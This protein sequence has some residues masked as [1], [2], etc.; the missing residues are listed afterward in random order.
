MPITCTAT[1][2][3]AIR[4]TSFPICQVQNLNATTTEQFKN[5]F[6]ESDTNFTLESPSLH[7][8]VNASLDTFNSVCSSILNSVAPLR[9]KSVKAKSEPW[10][11]EDTQGLRRAC[12]KAEC[13]WKKNKLLVSYNMLCE[14][15]ST[16]HNAVNSAKRKYFADLISRY[17]SNSNIL[18]NTIN[19]VLNP[20]TTCPVLYTITCEDLLNFFVQ[21]IYD[22][23]S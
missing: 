21:K 3:G 13:R 5:A 10:L 1:I 14:S 12:R 4:N 20:I 7:L 23:R 16:Y 8:D 22:N 17:H 18:F 2:P 9:V 6:L 11:N 15:L 19:S